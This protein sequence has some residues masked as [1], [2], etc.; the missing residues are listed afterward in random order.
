VVGIEDEGSDQ[1]RPGDEPESDREMW[2]P[3]NPLVVSLPDNILQKR[4]IACHA[5]AAL[6]AVYIGIN[7]GATVPGLAA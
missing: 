1:V 3:E 5:L 4:D 7:E 2:P 6:V